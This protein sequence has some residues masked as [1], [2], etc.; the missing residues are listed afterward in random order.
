MRWA[1]AVALVGLAAACGDSS[2]GE[3]EPAP[4]PVE[5]TIPVDTGSAADGC[6]DVIDARAERREDGGY[7]FAVTVSSPDTGWEKYADEWQVRATDGTVLGT[8]T[9][10][11]PHVDEQPFTR[12]LDGVD[13]PEGVDR[14]VIVARDSVE[15]YCGQSFTLEL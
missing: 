13:I 11:H 15:G 3:S 10:A 5:D 4:A 2:T 9:L 7:A 12:S 6:A 8:R 1:A 14:V